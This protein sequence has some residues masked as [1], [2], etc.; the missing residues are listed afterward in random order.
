MSRRVLGEQVLKEFYNAASAYPANFNFKSFKDFTNFIDSTSPKFIEY[1]GDSS[2]YTG[3]NIGDDTVKVII[4]NLGK[5]NMGKYSTYPDGSFKGQEFYDTLNKGAVASWGNFLFV[6]HAVPE[7]VK[8]AS[9][10]IIDA[11]TSGLKIG[12][13]VYIA[14]G[15]AGLFLLILSFRKK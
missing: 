13:S 2:F 11:A 7:A 5:S 3:H 9:S 14:A 15:A 8:Q 10:E 4:S 6:K 12:A 1:F